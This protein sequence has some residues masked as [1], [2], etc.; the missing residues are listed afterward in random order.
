MNG[1][2]DIKVY[3]IGKMMITN[4]VFDNIGCARVQAL[5]CVIYDSLVNTHQLQL[6]TAIKPASAAWKTAIKPALAAWITAIKPASAAWIT[7]IKP[8]SAA[9]IT[10]IKPASAA[11]KTA[12]GPKCASN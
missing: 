5:M 9:W 3:F 7:A 2:N 12:L 6:K 10:A 8:A 4:T 11:W 1:N